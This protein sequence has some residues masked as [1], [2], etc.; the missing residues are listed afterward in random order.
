VRVYA[1]FERPWTL[2]RTVGDDA[3]RQVIP[4]R[5]EAGLIMV[6][7]VDA[8]RAQSWIRRMRERPLTVRPLLLRT[9]AARYGEEAIERLGRLRWVRAYPWTDAVHVWRP[10]TDARAVRAHLRELEK[11]RLY[12]FGEAVSDHHGWMEGAVKTAQEAVRRWRRM[13]WP[14]PR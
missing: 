13:Q 1:R 14:E 2:P 5:P 12:V 8:E 9:L 7:Y 3:L 10:R 6:A 4:V 11:T